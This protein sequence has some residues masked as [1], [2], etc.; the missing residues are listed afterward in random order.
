MPFDQS[1]FGP[2]S[3]HGN[4]DMPNIWTYTTTDPSSEVLSA[5]YFFP[6]VNQINE[7]DFIF[8]YGDSYTIMGQFGSGLSLVELGPTLETS[9]ENEAARDAYYGQEIYYSQLIPDF[10][11][12][13]NIGNDTIAPF[14]WDGPSAPTSYDN[15]FWIQSSIQLAPASTNVGSRRDSNGGEAAQWKNTATNQSYTYVDD[16]VP[17]DPL[18]DSGDLTRDFLQPLETFDNQITNSDVISS[19]GP[20]NIT[21]YVLPNAASGRNEAFSAIPAEAG[22]FTLELRLGSFSMEP[23]FR[24]RVTFTETDAKV[25]TVTN[26]TQAANA[27]ISFDDDHDYSI[28]DDAVIAEIA[29]GMTEINNIPNEVISIPSPTS[30]EVSTD[31]TTFTAY[32]SGGVGYTNVFT[33]LANPLTIRTPGTLIYTSLVPAPGQTMS[34]RGGDFTI[35]FGLPFIPY[36]RARSRPVE[37][38][39]VIDDKNK[40]VIQYIEELAPQSTNSDYATL[41]VTFLDE[42]FEIREDKAGIHEVIVSFE[43]GVTTTNR[44]IVVGI[45]IDDVI[46]DEEF[47]M[48][49]KDINNNPYPC[50]SLPYNF[51]PGT[52]NLKVK[53]GA[54]GGIGAFV[55]LKNFRFIDRSE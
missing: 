4:S 2:I 44:Q 11:V 32:S 49:M 53:F 41:P 22:D 12:F 26:I 9:F 52:H 1:T 21:R 36:L 28:G 29:I 46:I 34:F 15:A 37:E 19:P 55:E 6:K 47:V 20:D 43:C 17:N 39:R 27:V 54:Q 3:A 23:I 30:I 50:K 38:V 35:P 8:I 51:T 31:T 5:N 24:Q 25:R 42:D 33:D 45:F 14:T 16:E 7:G 40:P 10:P 18:L 13:V 48:E